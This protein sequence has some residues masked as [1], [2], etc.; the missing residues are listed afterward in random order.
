MTTVSLIGVASYL[1]PKV[2]G[3]DFFAPGAATRRGMFTAPATRR[4][5]D[6]NETADHMIHRAAGTLVERLAP[7]IPAEAGSVEPKTAIAKAVA[8]NT[9]RIEVLIERIAI[10]FST[11]APPRSLVF[12]IYANTRAGAGIHTPQLK[13]A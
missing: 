2:V 6:A 1:P 13:R 7:R 11:A 8:D 4:H 12:S 9:R 3:N 10:S 5:V